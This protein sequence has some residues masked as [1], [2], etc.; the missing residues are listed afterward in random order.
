MRI[1]G[2]ARILGLTAAV[3]AA[4]A[5]GAVSLAAPVR[6]DEPVPPSAPQGVTATPGNTRV[7]VT[8][9][10]VTPPPGETI[11]DYVVTSSTGTGCPR[12]P[13]LTCAVTGL[14]NGARTAVRVRAAVGSVLG[15][16]S[17]AVEVVPGV[18]TAPTGVVA[19]AGPEQ[20]TVSFVAPSANGS[21]ILRYV[22]IAHDATDPARGHEFGIGATSPV[23]VTGLT[24]DDSYTFT[25]KAT[26]AV[27]TSAP[28]APSLPV[29]PGPPSLQATG[30]SFASVAIQQWVGQTSTLYGL[31]INWQVTSSIIGLNDFAANQVD[32][33]ASDIPYSSGQAEE[34]PDQPYQYLPDVG[35]GLAL[36]YNLN[37]NNGQRIT[38]LILDPAVI[39][40][41]FLGKVTTWDD[42]SIAALNPQLAGD[43]PSTRIT[44][45]YRCDA[46]GENY[47]LSEYL[48]SQDTKRFERAQSDFSQPDPGAAQRHLAD[49]ATGIRLRHPPGL[50][51]MGGRRAGRPV[52][53]GQRG[54]LR[55]S[56]VEHWGDHLRRNGVCHRARLPGGLAAQR[57]RQ[58][59]FSRP[60]PTSPRHFRRPPFSRT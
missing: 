26:N 9:D 55:R 51:G 14:H 47:L 7:V 60:R 4:V 59:R 27:G 46:G 25:V 2:C 45:V 15:P 31:D 56:T 35:A 41:I 39:D 48:L 16:Y 44:P 24:S 8:W 18:P 23:T 54:R 28:S 19:S 6:A 43:L 42:P 49:P 30:S 50:S 32:F 53:F 58:R 10:A 37:G 33:A 21:P 17:A 34:T 5:I 3:L 57:E 36:M 13:Y 29:T 38:S 22:V 40:R 1:I 11:T 52:R 20:A 12:D